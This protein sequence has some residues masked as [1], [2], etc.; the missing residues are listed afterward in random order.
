GALIPRP[1]TLRLGGARRPVT[2]QTT[3]EAMRVQPPLLERILIGHP[4]RCLG[5]EAAR[6]VRDRTTRVGEE[7]LDLPAE[8]ED[9]DHDEDRDE[10]ENQRVLGHRL[11]FLAL[12]KPEPG[13]LESYG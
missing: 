6:G 3:R 7:V 12:A 10:A 11:A 8:E 9:G 2:G 4:R 5:T 13:V 1:A